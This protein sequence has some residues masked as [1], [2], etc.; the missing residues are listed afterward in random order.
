VREVVIVGGGPAGAVC[1]Q[2]LAEAGLA[3]TLIDDHLAWEKPCGGALTEKALRAYPFLLDGPHPKK[4]VTEVE[5]RAGA[6]ARAR[7][8]LDEPIVIYSRHV[9]NGLLLDR[10]SRAGCRIVRARVTALQTE[11]VRPSLAAG[12]SKLAVDFIVVAAGAR[13]RLLPQAAPLGEPGRAGKAGS[14]SAGLLEPE[15]LE[16]TLGYYVPVQSDILKIKFLSSFRGYLW[17]FP[18]PDHLSVGICGKLDES[19]ITA[20]RS[21]LEV[22]MEEERLPRNGA[23]LYSHLLPSPRAETVRQRPVAGRNWAL[24]GDAAAAVDSI[25]GE[26]IYYAMRSGELLGRSLAAGCP[27]RYPELLR[28]ECG[29]ELERAAQ[30]APRFFFEQFLGGEV[31]TRT[32]EFARRSPTFRRLLAR[33]FSGSQDYRTLKR[34]LWI[35]LPLSLVEIGCSFLVPEASRTRAS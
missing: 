28:A 8:V 5:L 2:V 33:L 17:S 14:T 4:V 22:F 31:T 10:A 18:R 34:R 11:G 21:H 35:Q 9:L 23:R 13:N 16:Q 20:L 3:V 19:S 30:L 6:A 32:V 26:G 15:D 7:L 24:V 1:G 27:E 29:A 25:T 12:G